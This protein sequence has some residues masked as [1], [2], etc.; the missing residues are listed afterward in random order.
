MSTKPYIAPDTRIGQPIILGFFI[1]LTLTVA[2][3]VVGLSYISEA[4]RQLHT[5]VETQSVKTQFAGALQMALA[6]RSQSLQMALL[7]P[8]A[9]EK[10]AAKA[11][12]EASDAATLRAYH[13]LQKLPLTAQ[14]Q[15]L[16]SSIQKLI[17]DARPEL[18]AA[19]LH[20]D[21][22]PKQRRMVEQAA[23]F[24]RLQQEQAHAAL[25]DADSAATKAKALMLILSACTLAFGLFITQ[26][27]CRRVNAQGRQLAAQAKYDGLTSLPNRVML[28]ERLAQKITQAAR[29]NTSFAVMLMDLDR[30]KEVN[31]TLGH[32]FGDVLLK[33]VGQ[34]LL[35]TVRPDDIVARLGGDEYVVVLHDLKRCDVAQIAEKVIAAL[36]QPFPIDQQSIDV[37]AS[38][39]V[40]LF[41][42][43]GQTPSTL[44]READIAMYVAKR[45]G[46]G[47]ALYSPEQEKISRDDLSLKGELREA[48][49]GN[50]L[51]LHFQ[52]KIDHRQHR[53][54][55]F[56]ALVR[57]AHPQHGFMPPDKF[58][59]L[60]EQAGLIGA[61]TRWVLK[62]ALYQLADLHAQGHRLSMAVN[63]SACNLHDPRLVDNVVA[64][65]QETGISPQYLVLEITE[66]AVMSSPSDG[67]RN[68]HR[69]GDAGV[70]LA[71]D[72]FGTGYS[73]LAYLKQLPVDELK[74]DKSFVM[75]MHND[76]NDAVIVRST[77]DL[78]HNLGL[79]VTAEGVEN[80]DTWEILTMLGCDTSQGYF[81]SKPQSAEHL[82]QWLVESPW[83]IS[84][85]VEYPDADF[86]RSVQSV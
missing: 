41:P 73:S 84:A 62:A 51:V 4:N 77:I 35:E 9:A 66:G 28:V 22:M 80:R 2:L 60:S 78:A 45:R 33:E 36:E 85:P 50:Q 61:L 57:W 70:S 29:D 48:I 46:G 69:L 6:Q 79:K 1:S 83:A 65:L 21:A 12:F 18:Q 43:H 19:T 8:E 14:E 44:L 23:A 17:N 42:D 59:P 10:L 52:P 75:N 68:L 39:G 74:I 16:L 54:M 20:R 56:E 72:D 37:S 5:I 15:A 86:W 64:L 31:D 26:F 24:M 3:T 40:T 25:H 13:N 63:L 67:I 34:R 7:S 53:V 71:I 76:D 47:F 55:G 32:E 81:M 49:H 27:V 30:F 82:S 11:R 58:I 38:L